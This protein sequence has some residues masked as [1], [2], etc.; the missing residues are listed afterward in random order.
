MPA[1]FDQNMLRLI[2]QIRGRVPSNQK[3]KISPDNISFMLNLLEIYDHS[4]D[5]ALKSLIKQ[6]F[7]CVGHSWSNLL[8]LREP[9]AR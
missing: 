9:S 1:T 8:E 2:D 5:S 3:P 4:K 6:L 7:D